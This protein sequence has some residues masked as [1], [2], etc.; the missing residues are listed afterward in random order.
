MLMSPDGSLQPCQ[1]KAQLLHALEA[2]P[3]NWVFTN[4]L[5][6]P[7][8]SNTSIII[9]AMVVVQEQVVLRNKSITVKIYNYNRFVTDLQHKING[10]FLMT[11]Q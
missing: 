11:I 9:D 5:E 4:P 6:L 3:Q 10:L 1:D 7:D 8:N 2:H